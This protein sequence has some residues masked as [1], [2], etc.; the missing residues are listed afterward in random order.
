M[1]KTSAKQIKRDRLLDQGVQMLMDQGYHG[2]G[3]KEILDIV[4]IPK[5]SFYN[6]FASK[7]VFAAEAISHYIEP[8]LIRLEGHLQNPELDGLTA[9]KRYYAELICEVERIGYKGGC[10]MGNLMGEVGDTSEICRRSL[11]S[12]IERYRNLQ[13]TALLRAQNE[14]TVTKNLDADIMSNLLVDHWQGALLRMKIEQ[15]VHPLQ[16]FVET[17]LE[18]YFLKK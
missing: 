14:G 18:D 4:G 12:A 1:L 10:L 6:Y 17:F 15:S 7:E 11:K 8:F 13:K 9:L 3:L 5:G 16:Q 2:T